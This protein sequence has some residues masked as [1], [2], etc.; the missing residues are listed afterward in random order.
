MK[1]AFGR[2][3][4]NYRWQSNRSILVVGTAAFAASTLVVVGLNWIA[5]Y[6]NDA[7]ALQEMNS[8]EE[9]AK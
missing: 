6:L 7:D 5:D 2:Y 9:K 3:N 1:V 4:F 8:L